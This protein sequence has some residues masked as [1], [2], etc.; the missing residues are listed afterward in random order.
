MTKKNLKQLFFKSKNF[1]HKIQNYFE[2]YENNFS[3]YRNKNIKFVEIGV[4]NGGSLEVWKKYFGPKAKI[5]GID[6]N[7]ECKK[8]EDKQVKIFIG[9]QSDPNFWK[10][11]FK[12]VGKVDIILD[13]GGHTNLDQIITTVE[14]VKNIKDG[15]M[16][17][18]EDVLTSYHKKYNSHKNF[19]FMNFAKKITDDL[20]FK[21]NFDGGKKFKFSLNKY[22]YSV[23]FYSSCV[24]FNIDRRKT[25]EDKN[26]F[27]R[28]KNHGIENLTWKGNDLYIE[29]MKYYSTTKIY[30]NFLKILKKKMINKVLKKYFL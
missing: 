13:D 2:I 30:K 27:N 14:S 11:F 21:N 18:I 6:I 23:F 15:G 16:L 9:N 12:K 8:F 20:N 25:M 28:G 26:I 10:K 1:S 19:T 7:P 22:I 29:H 17:L 4:H 3:K 24:I 5:I